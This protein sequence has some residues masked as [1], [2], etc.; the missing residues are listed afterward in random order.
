M[1]NTRRRKTAFCKFKAMT[2]NKADDA[3][4]GGNNIFMEKLFNRSYGYR[5]GRLALQADQLLYRVG[6]FFDFLFCQR[7]HRAAAQVDDF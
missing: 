7:Y 1:N 5:P 2:S 6:R 4:S 3:G